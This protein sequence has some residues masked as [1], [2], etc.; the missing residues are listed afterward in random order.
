MPEQ[1]LSNKM[2]LN[3]GKIAALRDNYFPVLFNNDIIL[4][5]YVPTA[6]W[7]SGQLLDS[8]NVI[9]NTELAWM[10]ADNDNNGFVR[11]DNGVVMEDGQSYQALRTHPKWVDNGTIKGWLPWIQQKGTGIFKAIVGFLNGAAGTDGV[12]FQVWIHYHVDGV[13]RWESVV[14]QQKFYSGQLQEI[15][16]DLSKW[17]SQE[18]SVE[19]R[20]DAGP[21][22]GRDWA[23]WINPRIEVTIPLMPGPIVTGNNPAFF[24]DRYDITKKWY[25]P[26][27]KMKQPLSDSFT[28]SCVQSAQ[29]DAKGKHRYTGELTFSITKVTPEAII[30][31][32]ADTV[33]TYIEIPLNNINISYVDFAIGQP[34]SYSGT[35][36]QNNS[37]Y[38]L[39]LS[40]DNQLDPE[41]REQYL[42]ALFNFITQRENSAFS[43][44]TISGTYPG[45][46]EKP[47]APQFQIYQ[48]A[49]R[50][51]NIQLFHK[52]GGLEDPPLMMERQSQQE[53]PVRIMQRE[54]PFKAMAAMTPGEPLNN[55]AFIADHPLQDYSFNEKMVFMKTLANISYPC[56]GADGYPNNFIK[57]DIGTPVPVT[58]N[59]QLPFGDGAINQHI[60]TEFFPKD[61][62]L[63]NYGINKIYL[64]NRNFTYLIIPQEY[65]I[66]LEH[67]IDSS[68]E[69][70]LVPAAY[71]NTVVDDSNA[72]KCT[73]TFKFHIG[74]NLSAYQLHFIKKL[75]FDNNLSGIFKTVDDVPVDFPEKTSQSLPLIFDKVKE[76]V[77]T[78]LGSYYN[79]AGLS[80]YFQL[81]FQ[82]VGIGDGSAATIAA[83]LKGQMGNAAI[84]NTIFFDVD[85]EN[86]SQT[87]SAIN[88]SVVTVA[89]NG[90]WIDKNISDGQ[91]YMVNQTLYDISVNDLL[92]PDVNANAPSSNT[93]PLYVVTKNLIANVNTFP[94]A[95]KVTTDN[96]QLVIPCY[97][98]SAT[99]EYFDSVLPELRIDT[100]KNVSDCFI[101]T[102]NTGLFSLYSITKIDATVYILAATETDISKAFATVLL[103]ITQDGKINNINFVLPVGDYIAGWSVVYATCITFI[104]GTTKQ[105]NV[106]V[107]K[108]INSIGKVINLT[109]SVLNLS[110]Q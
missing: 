101:I 104:D 37:E 18:I 49:F 14:R 39:V 7:E 45:Y 48:N 64:N 109:A 47:T 35:V 108:D 40:P 91:V 46:T 53:K 4:F 76:A 26:E 97:K 13:E 107:I 65:V 15:T 24:N 84:V 57:K 11:L 41:K 34:I 51:N 92:I 23:A 95:I 44:I 3:V 66:L 62:L 79:G 2:F 72:D 70:P 77:L 110:K 22:S 58:F 16:A 63:N 43:T 86:D 81:E 103:S 31:I 5:N 73:A 78:P 12:T 30:S 42:E 54:M 36:S 83:T 68:H 75:I 85:S 8:D 99:K 94:A 50:L 60:F 33:T 87:Q 17:A 6:R 89:G 93:N 105:N 67:A 19:L 10:G 20:V 98:Y 80:R 69:D 27:F 74:P 28:F 71:L 82:G 1:V 29:L 52:S 25:L 106:Q 96:Y 100:Q 21:S 102:N 38:T 88:L 59:C 90:L 55:D 32:P 56:S 61:V 9:S